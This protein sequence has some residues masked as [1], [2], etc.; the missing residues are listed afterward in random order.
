MAKLLSKK[1][2]F[3]VLIISILLVAMF[4]AACGKTTAQNETANNTTG[5]QATPKKITVLAAASLTESYNEIAKEIKKD[6]NI[7]VE[8]SFA[9][10]QQLVAS[11]E[12]GAPAD[13]FASANTKY[14]K[15]LKDEG[16]VENDV[17]FAHNKLI[18]AKN[19]SSKAE[20][21]SFKDL[22]KDGVKL[23]VGDKS[24][25]VG[26]YFFTALDNALADKTIDQATY[27]KINANIK[28]KELNVKDVVSK[29]NLGDADAG[30]IY[31]TDANGQKDL[32]VIDVN[33]FSK[34]QVDY[35]VGI[36][37]DSKN[38]DT[39]QEFIDYITT[40]K[41]KDILKNHGFTVD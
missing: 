14:M 39:A 4:S 7:D 17:I 29:V 40:G 24:V 35:P 32:E 41:G 27:D 37:K 38:K 28:S 16:K 8:L 33:E 3:T 20:I 2:K 11:I 10:S 15:T 23:V 21:N 34:L 31:K 12:Q 26:K 6:K 5:N 9:G 22:A 19:K 25:P 13:V 18:I 30:V 1:C 36:V